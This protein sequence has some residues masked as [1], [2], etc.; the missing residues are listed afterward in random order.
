[1][2]VARFINE[3][4]PSNCY[5]IYDSSTIDGVCIVVDPGSRNNTE[6][7]S[8]LKE[9]SLTPQY[10]VL[11]HEHF[12]HI[13]GVN[14]LVLIYKV[15]IV[16]SELC[17]QRI[18]DSFDNCSAMYDDNMAVVI[19]GA[20]IS[21]ESIGYK[22]IFCGSQLEFYETPGHSDASVCF[23]LNG[24]LFT[25]DALL[26][27]LK[28]VTKLPTGSKEKQ[29]YTLRDLYTMQGQG[30]IVYPGH[31]DSFDLDGYDLSKAL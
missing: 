2:E 27:D 15:P 14:E 28:T 9:N 23:V 30:L 31:G 29:R 20:T 16:C 4:V 24:C 7:L 8:Y 22:L 25:G 10:I 17:S 5:V 6:L 21:I 13:W 11:T 26:K 3:P 12:D 18:K 1:M 19:D